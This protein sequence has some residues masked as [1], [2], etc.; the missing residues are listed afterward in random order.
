MTIGSP[1]GWCRPAEACPSMRRMSVPACPHTATPHLPAAAPAIVPP[2]RSWGMLALLTWLAACGDDGS[3]SPTTSTTE[4]G[5]GSTGATG[6]TGVGPTTEVDGTTDAPSSSSTSDGSTDGASSTSDGASTSSSTDPSASGSSS[7]DGT[8]GPAA[9]DVPFV[10][11]DPAGVPLTTRVQP[12]WMVFTSEA[13]W[14]AQTGAPVPSGVSLPRQWLVYGSRGPQP[15]PGHDVQPTALTWDGGTL[16]VEGTAGEPAADCETYQFTWPA[17][18]LLVI[19]ALEVEVSAVDDQ[20]VPQPNG[21]AMGAGDSESCDLETPCATGLLC[22]GL[23]RSTVLANAPGG[24]CLPSTY[25][26]VFT[27]GALA[28]PGD[29]TPAETSQLVGGLTSVDMDVVIWVELD[30]PAPQELVIELRNPSGNQV[31]VASL[32]SSPL[33]PGG[34]GIVPTGFSGDESVNG[35]W[36]LVVR[37]EVVNANNGS[38]SAWEL[39]IM[40][41]FD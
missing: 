35:T 25:A 40:S 1:Q 20:T 7:E 39:E 11:L 15:F 24:L 38:V 31:P 27:G 26:G 36:W 19:D 41:R 22:A 32:Q 37:D 9:F 14:V 10:V 16:V 29:G 13:E 4:A 33:H 3:A 28:I 2:R 12:G 6:T 34:V 17:D 8:T 30:H 21:C 23:I 18:T 5:T